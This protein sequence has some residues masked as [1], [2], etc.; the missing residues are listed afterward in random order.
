MKYKLKIVILKTTDGKLVFNLFGY[1]KLL[2]AIFG[3]LLDGQRGAIAGF[4]IGCFF[5]MHFIKKIEPPKHADLRLNFLMLG[6][7]ILQ[8]TGLEAAFSS[9]TIR[10]R[11]SHQFGEVYVDR[12]M[13]FFKEL[14]RQRI[15]VEKIC[16][17]IKINASLDEKI[18][19][20]KFLFEVSS[21]PKLVT[22]QLIKTVEYL[23]TRIDLDS[24]YIKQLSAEYTSHKT[25]SSAQNFRNEDPLP[26]Q[27]AYTLF[28]LTSACTEKELKK[29]YHTLAKKYHPD[30]HPDLLLAEK[31]KLQEKFRR[32]TEMYE[33]IKES[34]GWK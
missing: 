4:I 29:A 8:V 6:A 17:Q 27:D 10:T 24:K 21:H 31:N 15:Q 18:S 32:I 28:G 34:R 30:A 23:A 11:L 3:A 5:D 22:E 1:H 7:F 20:F 14:L 9:E 33:K 26:K 16:D 25:N 19:L 12:R 2:L 13:N